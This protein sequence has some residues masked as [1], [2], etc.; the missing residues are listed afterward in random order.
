MLYNTTYTVVYIP[1]SSMT[2]NMTNDYDE[3]TSLNG[4]KIALANVGIILGAALFSLLAEGEGSIFYGIFGNVSQAYLMAGVLFGI[5]AIVIMLLCT[6]NI[7]ERFDNSQPNDKSFFRTL[8]EFFKLKEFRNIMLYYLLSMIGFDII[9]AVFMFF[10]NYSLNF[11]AAAD[12]LLGMIFVA[13]PLVMAIITAVLWVKLSEKF[14]KHKV[15]MFA[16]F[17]MFAVLITALFVP[18]ENV[19]TTVLLCVFAGAGMSAIQILPFASVPD[20]V[21]VDEYY[22]GVRREGA[23]YGI[24]QFM[25]K[26]ASGVSIAIVSLVLAA[27]GYIE[28]SDGSFIV[29]PDSALMAIRVVLGVIPGIIFLVSI[30]FAF[31]ANLSRGKYEEIKKALEERKAQK[32]DNN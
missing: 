28:S 20:V 29:Q 1:Y 3:R 14:Q 22:N 21:E 17:Y 13:I 19:L 12:S 26:I 7:R 24:I 16:C 8:K 2:A 6:C 5:V 30:I 31:R 25:Y 4:F 10:I 11:G 18:Q 9:M 23:Y 15:Y 32:T 27:F